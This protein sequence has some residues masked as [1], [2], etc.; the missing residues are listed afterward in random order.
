MVI[1]PAGK[2]LMGSPDTGKDDR[3]N[4]LPQHE[5]TIA[6]P[7]AVGRYEVTLGEWNACFRSGACADA[8]GFLKPSGREAFGGDSQPVFDVSWADVEAYIK[9]LNGVSGRNYRLLSE[10]EWEYA[11]RAGTTTPY[12]WGAEHGWGAHGNVALARDRDKW[13]ASTAPVGSFPPNQFGLYDMHGNVM[14][15]T[16]DC[17]ND[18]Y[19]GAPIDGSAWMSGD[20]SIHPVRGG[21]FGWPPIDSAYRL[22]GV[23]SVSPRTQ[24]LWGTGFR[25]ARAL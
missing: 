14:E 2:Y 25:L 7:Y 20:C 24:Y 11:A 5:V 23:D 4:E 16:Q 6:K 21:S 8:L 13:E 18:N 22:S 15:W 9:W 17:W 10:A 1:I 12:P 19:N 3:K